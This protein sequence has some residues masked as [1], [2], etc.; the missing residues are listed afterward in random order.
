[1][2]QQREIF[3]DFLAFLFHLKNYYFLNERKALKGGKK[4]NRNKERNQK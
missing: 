2:R 4:K 3:V 1:M